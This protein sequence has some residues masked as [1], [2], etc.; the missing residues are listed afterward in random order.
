MPAPNPHV[1]D[2]PVQRFGVRRVYTLIN[3]SWG[4]DRSAGSFASIEFVGD[5]GAYLKKELYGNVDF[6]DWN[7]HNY[8]N[9]INGTTTVNVFMVNAGQFDREKRV[10]MQIIELP[11]AFLRE[12]LVNIRITDNGTDGSQRLLLHG[13]TVQQVGRFVTHFASGGTWTTT[14][15]LVNVGTRRTA[16]KLA[17]FA[18]SGQPLPLPLTFPQAGTM[19]PLVVESLERPLDPGGTL[20]VETTG[21]ASQPAL[22]GWMELSS[23][24]TIT[25]FA[26]FRQNLGEVEREAVVPF[27]ERDSDAYVLSFDNTG[28]CVYG[29]AVASTS[30]VPANIQVVVRDDTGATLESTTLPLP[31]QGHTSFM[32]GDRFSSTRMRRG[33]VEFR[34]PP[35][36]HVSVLGLRVSPRGS[37]TTV[38][39]VSK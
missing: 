2:I 16:A 11:P 13:V 8:T 14:V 19:Y 35:Q 3:T 38:P 39:V 18:N 26:V 29:V 36:G 17:F 31:S 7:R 27:E 24:G 1:L 4:L 20:V 28:G 10:D 23:S 22:E 32:L 21:P 30:L 15:T 12:N 6:R 9:T 25:G 34:R 37:L 33:T 5:G